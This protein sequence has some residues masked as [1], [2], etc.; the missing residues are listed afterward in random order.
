MV[1]YSGIMNNIRS[2]FL[3]INGVNVFLFSLNLEGVCDNCKG[4]GIVEMN[5]V[6]MESIKSIC[7]VCEGKKFKKE[8][9]EYRF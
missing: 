4:F 1:I 9:L 2:I 3:K 6:F 7:N 8:V 5:F